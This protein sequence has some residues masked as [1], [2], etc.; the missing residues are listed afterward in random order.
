MLFPLQHILGFRSPA[1]QDATK[2]QEVVE[3]C[4]YL[5]GAEGFLSPFLPSSFEIQ[6]ECNFQL[7]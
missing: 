1:W 7:I 6:I 3:K 5:M 2:Q 4:G